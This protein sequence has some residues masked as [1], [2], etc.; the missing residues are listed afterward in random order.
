MSE[1]GSLDSLV[2]TN[3]ILQVSPHSFWKAHVIL[4][5]ALR[6]TLSTGFYSIADFKFFLLPIRKHENSSSSTNCSCDFSGQVLSFS[7]MENVTV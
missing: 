1:E 4:A 3:F 6:R 2:P 7:G 5:D